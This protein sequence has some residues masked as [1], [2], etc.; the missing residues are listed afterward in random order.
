[1]S[2]DIIIDLQ[3]QNIINLENKH[4]IVR[5]INDSILKNLMKETIIYIYENIKNKILLNKIL[6]SLSNHQIYD[7]IYYGDDLCIAIKNNIN[8]VEKLI[9]PIINFYII[10]NIIKS[11]YNTYMP[12][13][14]IYSDFNK[15]PNDI[16]ILFQSIYLKNTS[17]LD[18]EL[19]SYILLAL[20]EAKNKEKIL[21]AI[22]KL[23]LD[24]PDKQLLQY[25]LLSLII[26]DYGSKRTIED[27]QDFYLE[28]KNIT[29]NR[30]FFV[31][32]NVLD[33]F[34]IQ[35]E[36]RAI[37]MQEYYDEEY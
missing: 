15:I 35:D 33:F 19:A 30:V 20:I 10:N 29:F 6:F 31:I 12:L 17:I 11:I 28:C 3:N 9:E 2:S 13:Q 24:C 37:N 23:L 18:N 8:I 22:K 27:V 16:F 1:M 26:H 25:C 32:E 36:N 34:D 21:K 5:A 4:Y 7:K 14:Y